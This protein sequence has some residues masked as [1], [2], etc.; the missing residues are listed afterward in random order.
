M[1]F[2]FHSLC[3][4]VPDLQSDGVGVQFPV[5]SN[6]KVLLRRKKRCLQP[7]VEKIS[8]CYDTYDLGFVF[9]SLPV[10]FSRIFLF[11]QA[12]FNHQYAL[13]ASCAPMCKVLND[14]KPDVHNNKGIYHLEFDVKNALIILVGVEFL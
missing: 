14:T 3:F 2:Q 4:L 1:L 6:S 11:V 13:F 5:V 9:L 8:H 12:E 7:S 10:A